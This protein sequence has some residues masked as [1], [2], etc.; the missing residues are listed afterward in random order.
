MKAG[1]RIKMN[2]DDRGTT[3]VEVLVAFTVLM[4]IL[5]ILYGMISFASVLRMRAQDAN[6]ASQNFVKEMYS[7]ENAPER[8]EGED[9]PYVKVSP[10]EHIIVRNY[11]TKSNVPLFYL[12]LNTDDTAAENF[13]GT[14]AETFYTAQSNDPEDDYMLSLYNIEAVTY[15]YKPENG[16]DSEHIIIP[17]AV[18]FIHKEDRNYGE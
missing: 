17:K 4:I 7:K 6:T 12:S 16:V 2:N 15:E 13:A 14:N 18:N 11:E 8:V 1:Y 9:M 5:A 10:H 3:M